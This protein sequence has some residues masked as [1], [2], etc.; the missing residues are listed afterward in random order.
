MINLIVAATKE[1][2]IGYKGGLPWYIKEEIEYFNTTT[3]CTGRSGPNPI[4]N[5]CIM[6]RKTWESIPSKFKPLAGRINIVISSTFIEGV[7]NF[8]NVEL[9]ITYALNR[10]SNIFIIGGIEIFNSSIKFVD[11]VYITRIESR[12]VIKCDVF[13]KPNMLVNF[14]L[15]HK[16]DVKEDGG[17]VF[18]F[19]IFNKIK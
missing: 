10:K 16:S 19:Q 3:T 5:T 14:E 9:A 6:G 18:D 12:D 7:V 1:G 17:Y 2:G 11:R 15:W 8:A 4:Q 13:L